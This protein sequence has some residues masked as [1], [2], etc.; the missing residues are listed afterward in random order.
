MPHHTIDLGIA[1]LGRRG[2]ALLRVGCIVFQNQF[3]LDL[4]ATDRHALGVQVINGHASA[5]LVVLAVV[6]LGPGDWCHMT[7]ANRD[8]LRTNC[9]RCQNQ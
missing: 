3:K 6:S 9:A 7:D 1:Q 4:L 5:V 2:G 8:S